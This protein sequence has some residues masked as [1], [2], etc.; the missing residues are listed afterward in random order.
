MSQMM[1]LMPF[2]VVFII[3]GLGLIYYG[4]SLIKKSKAGN[5]E[6]KDKNL[7]SF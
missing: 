7:K 1:D 4:V 2:F 6:N 3:I 5:L